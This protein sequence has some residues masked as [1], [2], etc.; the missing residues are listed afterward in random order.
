MPQVLESLLLVFFSVL[1]LRLPPRG[2][3]PP[4]S[5]RLPRAD[6]ARAGE[7]RRGVGGIPAGGQ[8]GRRQGGGEGGQGGGLGK[9]IVVVGRVDAFFFYQ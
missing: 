8:G 1:V 3:L 7:D 9:V 6:A 4:R 5:D 2:G